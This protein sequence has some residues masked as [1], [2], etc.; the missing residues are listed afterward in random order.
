MTAKLEWR[1]NILRHAHVHESTVQT[2]DRGYYSIKQ[3]Y[4][5]EYCEFD[6]DKNEYRGWKRLK[7]IARTV[8]HAKQIAEAHHQARLAEEETPAAAE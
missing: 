6:H 3:C 2:S 5:I 1:D 7:E 4:Y 8:E